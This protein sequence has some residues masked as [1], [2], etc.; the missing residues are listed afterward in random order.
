MPE[1]DDQ[2]PRRPGDRA[3]RSCEAFNPPPDVVDLE[4]HLTRMGERRFYPPS[5][6]G[7]PGGLAWLKSTRAVRANFAAWLVDPAAGLGPAHFHNLA[8]YRHGLSSPEAWAVPW[9]WSWRPCRFLP[10]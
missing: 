10:T 7:W 6:A 9:P 2:E 4:I 3:I 5:V 1:Q 8:R